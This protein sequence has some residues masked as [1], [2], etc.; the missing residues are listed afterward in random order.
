MRLAFPST[1]KMA[2]RY[3][4]PLHP[5]ARLTLPVQTHA[6]ASQFAGKSRV[7]CGA[8]PC[9]VRVAAVTVAIAGAAV[10][11]QCRRRRGQASACWRSS[12]ARHLLSS[13]AAPALKQKCSPSV[14]RALEDAPHPEV[15]LAYA[16]LLDPVLP[17]GFSW[18]DFVQASRRPVRP[19]VR[20]NPL[21]ATVETVRRYCDT[22]HWRFAEAVPWATGEAAVAGHGYWVEA[23]SPS[24][25]FPPSWSS[26]P[27]VAD[28][29]MLDVS[30]SKDAAHF[31][32]E[33]YVQ[34]AASLVPVAALVKQFQGKAPAGALVL[35]LAAAPGGKTTAL[36]AWASAS[37]GAV[38]ANEPSP[39]RSKALVD[40]L[41]RLGAMPWTMITQL[42]GAQAGRHWPETFHA[43]L[44]DAPCSGESLTRRG[45]SPLERWRKSESHVANIAAKQRFLID[46]AF[47]SL[48]VG[49]ILVYSTCT[50][51]PVENEQVMEHLARTFGD[52]V[53]SVRL[54]D[55]A[56]TENML[57]PD[58]HLR[59]WPHIHDT[60][61]FFVACV[62]KLHSTGNKSLV[63]PANST[64]GNRQ[65]SRFTVWD[66]M[67]AVGR[68]EA[69]IVER[70]FRAN[71]GGQAWPPGGANADHWS[72]RR[73]SGE[74]WLCPQVLGSLS[75]A[76]L[77]R[78]GIRL[79]GE[80][81]YNRA[82]AADFEWCLSF[83]HRLPA[84]SPCVAMLDA[85]AAK[86]F[87]SGDDVN[88]EPTQGELQHQDRN[89]CQAVARFEDRVLG[90]GRWD[91]TQLHNDTPRHWR[92]DGIM[93]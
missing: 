18:D 71:L 57:T 13:V 35:D 2:L 6:T 93:L 33:L 81:K 38:V 41:L 45:G 65:T 92:C 69:R 36:A 66:V 89:G 44:L 46:S 28:N 34:E 26:A 21:K 25:E 73:R 8:N 59:C 54:D 61:G 60:Q 85:D 11:Q 40:N 63:K 15:P 14:E 10:L 84:E 53:E 22:N 72:L 77:R 31:C 3:V 80:R 62:R 83:A 43:V 70:A 5:P 20:V 76:G 7:H 29:G 86:A 50:L 39:D 16:R 19:C 75:S 74:I 82:F 30:W 58:G 79:A 68:K 88:V 52:A 78:C 56:G 51:N 27:L 47:R 87:C 12:H 64:R 9:H 67:N 48:R 24:S 37:G 23:V 1:K 42:D 17:A 55:V 32:G 90:F 4:T 49:G 91:G